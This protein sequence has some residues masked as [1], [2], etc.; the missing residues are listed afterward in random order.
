MKYSKEV[1]KSRY[2][3]AQI[4]DGASIFET[5]RIDKGCQ[6]SAEAEV[7]PGS[8]L[9]ENVKLIGRVKIGGNVTIKENVTLV[10]PLK[11]SD[12][13]Y[14]ARDCI[15]GANRPEQLPEDKETMIGL[16]CRIGK[17]SEI[18]GG[19]Q[20]GQHVWVRAGSRVIGDVPSYGLVSRSPA[21]LERFACP[22]C[23]SN[24]VVK[25]AFGQ[26]NI[27]VCVSCRTQEYRFSKETIS[28]NI[29]RVLL[30]NGAVGECVS[31]QGDNHIWRHE[32]ELE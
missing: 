21:I 14:I 18:H 10:G 7:G 1:Y 15:I 16:G 12:D 6:I 23:G 30:P 9:F 17:G 32:K 8:V 4:E 26:L 20:L 24:L 2:P 13:T 28:K 5:C 25:R 31:T 27:M 29:S 11:I 22:K 3:E 19:L